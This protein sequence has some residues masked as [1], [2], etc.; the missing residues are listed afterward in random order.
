MVISF[1]RTCSS[2]TTGATHRFRRLRRRLVRVRTRDRSVSTPRPGTADAMS[3]AYVEA[4]AACALFP[5]R[6]SRCFYDARGA[7]SLV[8]RLARRPAEIHEARQFAPFLASVATQLARCYL[9]ASRCASAR[10]GGGRG[11]ADALSDRRGVYAGGAMSRYEPDPKS[12][13]A[14]PVPGLVRGRQVRDLRALESVVHSAWRRAGFARRHRA[15]QSAFVQHLSPYAEWYWN[16][17][18]QSGSPTGRASR[19]GLGTRR[20]RTSASPSTPC[21]RFGIRPWRISLRGSARTIGARHEA[22]QRLSVCGR[23]G[24]QPHQSEV[25]ATRDVVGDLAAAVRARGMRFGVYYSAG[26]TGPSSARPMRGIADASAAVRSPR[27]T[28]GYADAHYRELIERVR[29]DVLWN[30]ISY[31]PHHGALGGC[32]GLLRRDPGRC[33]ERPL[34]PVAAMAR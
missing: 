18:A 9:A 3:R 21:C 23:L 25:A 1:P 34:P 7:R 17:I 16:A 10:E 15:R 5:T 4:I 28:S 14:H 2:R 24:A 22:P 6:T 11:P 8:P 26:S 32:R 31:P 33:R 13:R 12:L 19:R 29:R 27:H 20:T 30:D